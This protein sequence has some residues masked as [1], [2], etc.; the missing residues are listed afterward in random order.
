MTE[1]FI[2]SI[3]LITQEEIIGTVEVLETEN[4]HG[5]LIQD[6]MIVEELIDPSV[7]PQSQPYRGFSLSKWIRSSTDSVFY[8]S[9]EKI[10]TISELTGPVL[11]L[12]N[13]ALNNQKTV[14]EYHTDTK[15]K[16]DGYRNYVSDARKK[17]EDLFK[18]Y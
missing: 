2:A 6:P 3:K 7:P 5:V 11:N 15:Q 9:M 10:V 14:S 4:D 12:Y 16:Y 1:K 18:N 8:I 13:K 17:F